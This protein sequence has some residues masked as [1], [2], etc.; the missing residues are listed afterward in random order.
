MGGTEPDPSASRAQA[1]STAFRLTS[2]GRDGEWPGLHAREAS[3]PSRLMPK[4]QNPA[5]VFPGPVL[6][7]H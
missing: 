5:L 7:S 2:L 1:L 4:D 3:V 6:G